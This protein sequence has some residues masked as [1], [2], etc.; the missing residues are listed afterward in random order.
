MLPQ[1]WGLGGGSAGMS[2]YYVR[3]FSITNFGAVLP[4]QKSRRSMTLAGFE[5]AIGFVMIPISSTTTLQSH[6]HVN[7][8]LVGKPG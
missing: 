2:A 5:R 1:Y 7:G 3:L 4:C 6:P 8:G